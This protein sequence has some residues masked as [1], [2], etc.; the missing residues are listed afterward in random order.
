[1]GW[2]RWAA[3]RAGATVLLG[4]LLLPE[5]SFAVL[6]IACVVIARTG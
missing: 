4:G 1:M 6:L 2:G 3:T 5:P